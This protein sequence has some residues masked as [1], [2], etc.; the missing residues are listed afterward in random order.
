MFPTAEA[1]NPAES[2]KKRQ[3]QVGKC[4]KNKTSDSCALCRKAAWRSALSVLIVNS[5][6]LKEGDDS[7]LIKVVPVKHSKS[8]GKIK[9]NFEDLEKAREEEEKQ[10]IEGEKKKRYE[11]HRR[12]FR[13]AKRLSVSDDS[14]TQTKEVKEQSTPGKLK[15]TFEEIERERQELRKQQAEEE[16]KRRLE[17]EKRAFEEAKL[18]MAVLSLRVTLVKKFA[19]LMQQQC[20]CY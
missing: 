9:V 5:L 7:L 6:R 16:A 8:P 17:E 18:H 12:S 15:L 14:E 20:G 13:E 19:S 2:R 10:K 1:G 11:E 4:N 3:C